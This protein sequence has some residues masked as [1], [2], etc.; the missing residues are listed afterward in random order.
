[1]KN[2]FFNKTVDHQI[3]VERANENI[4][5]PKDM[6]RI[7]NDVFEDLSRMIACTIGPA[8]GNTLVTEPYASTPIFPSKDGFRVMNNHIYDNPAYE[9]IYRIVRDISG[10]MNETVGDATTS[11]VI[12]ANSFYKSIKKYLKKHKEITPY[13]IANILKLTLKSIEK[14]LLE[15]GYIKNISD[16]PKEKRVE[17]Y[18]KIAT[19]SA[20]NDSEI[21]KKV[22]DIYE[23]STSDYAYIDIQQSTNEKDDIEVNLGFEIPYGYTHTH[24]A[25]SADGITA[26]YDDPLFLLIDGPILDPDLDT[27]KRYVKIVTEELDNPR[28]LVIIAGEYSK[29][30][31]DFLTECRTGVVRVIR[32]TQVVVKL[33]VLSICFNM[34][35]EMGLS[36]VQDLEAI[37]GAK[38]I[39]TH[40]GRLQQAPDNAIALLGMLGRADHITTKYAYTRIRG[41]GGSE[42]E[43]KGRIAEIEKIYNATKDDA[44]HG[45]LAKARLENLKRRMGM[46]QGEMHCIRVGGD[47]YKS[48]VNRSLIYEDAVQAVKACIDHG[49]TLGGQ[50][51]I[52]AAITSYKDLM[53]DY[54]LD[55]AKNDEENP[56]NIII[57]EN[58]NLRKIVS[59]ILDI[60]A[61]SSSAAFKAVFANASNNKRW[62]NTVFKNISKCANLE[63]TNHA[64]IAGCP[65]FSTYN[66]ILGDYESFSEDF[67]ENIP[68]LIVPG[69]TDIELLNSVFEIVNLFVTSNQLISLLPKPNQK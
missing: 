5:P 20:N 23:K 24:M 35:N 21:G 68:N 11:G 26:E 19:I 25:N 60:V 45:T 18:K 67:S 9:S 69:N 58:K 12:I 31:I 46:L 57:G 55:S 3:N 28:P 53:I 62:I 43:R 66:L 40:N 17:I 29:K 59:D 52:S 27:L 16:L 61:E 2:T 22:A 50:V 32:N 14:V 8:G 64:V 44:Q 54:I 33:P 63:K 1:M 51:A 4:V 47:S 37:L 36:K 30:V 13:G 49:I 7:I 39:Q 10:R 15:K 6:E 34:M 65:N 42:A 41:G 56:I 38:A 48:K